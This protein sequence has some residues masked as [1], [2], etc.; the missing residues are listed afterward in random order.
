LLGRSKA[1]RRAGIQGA[2][3]P[4]PPSARTPPTPPS[5]I[6]TTS[7]IRACC[8]GFHH[9]PAMVTPPS[10]M[11]ALCLYLFFTLFDHRFQ[12]CERRW[13]S[14]PRRAPTPGPPPLIVPHVPPLHQPPSVGFHN[15]SR[16]TKGT[17]SEPSPV[18]HTAATLGFCPIRTESRR[19][20]E[21]GEGKGG[22][23]SRIVRPRG[24][25][26][27]EPDTTGASPP[28]SSTTRHRIDSPRH[29]LLA[30]S[31]A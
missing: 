29:R 21:G 9:P 20:E 15:R 19:R 22:A 30:A 31:P 12:I 17:R 28:S 23:W 16:P 18:H 6:D 2:H 10:A 4:S 3:A 27:P 14:Y 8:N 5:W 26:S 25:R 7:M 24:Y 11:A 13:H 1:A